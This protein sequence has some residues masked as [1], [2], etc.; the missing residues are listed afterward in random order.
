M[1]LVTIMIG[2]ALIGCSPSE[3]P[4]TLYR[5]SSAVGDTRFHVFTFDAAGDAGYNLSSCQLAAERSQK[6][7]GADAKFWC[8]RG[9]YK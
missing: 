5:T 9:P 8:E 6:Q 1:R 3:D 4:Y 7:H 2:L